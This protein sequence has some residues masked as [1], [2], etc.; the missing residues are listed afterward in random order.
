MF[1]TNEYFEGKV[2]S[3]AFN[4]SSTPATI[5]VMAKGDYTFSTNCIEHMTLVTGQWKIRLDKEGEFVEYQVGDKVVIPADSSF[6][7]QI[8]IDSAYLCEYI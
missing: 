6:D 5:G 1:T 7:L 4:T 2:K 8:L 3:I